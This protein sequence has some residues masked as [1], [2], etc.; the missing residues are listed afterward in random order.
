MSAGASTHLEWLD[1]DE[2]AVAQFVPQVRAL[3]LTS[4]TGLQVVFRASPTMARLFLYIHHVCCDGIGGI[5]LLGELLAR[6]G[7]K[8]AAPGERQPVFG[9]GDDVGPELVAVLLVALLV[10]GEEV[11]G[12]HGLS[13]EIDGLHVGDSP[14]HAIKDVMQR[15]EKL[16]NSVREDGV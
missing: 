12:S 1:G 11:L 3:D 14:F 7:Q 16:T 13:H 8:T 9:I 4:E 15:E 5:Q 2:D 6:Y 10:R